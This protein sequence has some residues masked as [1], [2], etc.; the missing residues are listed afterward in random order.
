MKTILILG[1]Y[2]YT[3]KLLTKHLLAQTDFNIIIAGRNLDK[4]QALAAKLDD[5][6]LTAL[7]VDA[8]DP[9]SLRPALQGVSMCLVA[10]PVTSLNLPALIRSCMEAGLDYLDIQYSTAKINLLNS[11]ATEIKQKNLCFITE[12]GYH[13]GL[14]AA[15]IRYAVSKLDS[16]ESA[17]TA[18]YLNM[19]GNIPYTEAVD[20]LMEGF[21][22]YQSQVFKNG[23]W[24]K[25][26]SWDMRKFDFGPE[27]G[28]RTCYSMF[29]EELRGLPE[30]YPSLKETGFYIS[31][32]N[33]I[34]DALITPIVMFGLK[35]APKRSIRP[36]GK[37][38]WWGMMNLSKPPYRVSLMVEAKGQLN[39]KQ[40]QVNARCEHEDGYELTAIPVVAFLMQYEKVRCP[41]LHMMGHL[42]EPKQLFANIQK[43]GANFIEA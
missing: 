32:S 15:L 11:L 7:R 18:G 25:P 8:A 28:K 40:I 43:M 27:L 16:I 34:T 35:I 17:V 3:G 24:T 42:A 29:F 37:L 5:P 2:G 41:G 12:A 20:E 26:K 1:G 31:G 21:K 14:P 36:L 6:R 13:P 19:G 30:I 23:A 10:A 9:A 38:M 33:F 39:G 4:A 22:D